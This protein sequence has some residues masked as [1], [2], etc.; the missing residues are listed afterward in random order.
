MKKVFLAISLLCAS[1]YMM[2][3]SAE[4]E[5]LTFDVYYDDVNTL[6]GHPRTPVKC[7]T[8]SIVGH[9]LYITGCEDCILQL[10]LGDKTVYSI[11]ITADTVELPESLDGNYELRIV[12]GNYCFWA[13]IEL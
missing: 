10:M 11:V 13:E 1:A 5:P 3:V 8:A 9:T 2:P 7:P 6:P 12:Q 4:E